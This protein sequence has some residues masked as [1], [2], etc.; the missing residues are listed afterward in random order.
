MPQYEGSI[1][2]RVCKPK[3]LNHLG[4]MQTAQTNYTRSARQDERNATLLS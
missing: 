2:N 4:V 3:K 1:L